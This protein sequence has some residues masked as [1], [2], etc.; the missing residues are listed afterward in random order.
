MFVITHALSVPLCWSL[1]FHLKL[2]FGFRHVNVKASCVWES[3]NVWEH[4]C[5]M[6][7]MA[8]RSCTAVVES[9]GP[10]TYM[11]IHIQYMLT[12][13]QTIYHCWRKETHLL[14][15]L[16]GVNLSTDSRRRLHHTFVVYI[17]C[18]CVSDEKI[19][20]RRGKG[21]LGD[22]G[23]MPVCECSYHTACE[24]IIPFCP[25]CHKWIIFSTLA[26]R[27]WLT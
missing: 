24:P 21:W 22:T 18:V 27:L 19:K 1:M 3:I 10:C 6:V 12:H 26:F 15:L 9:T 17:G 14:S 5:A 4:L 23:K 13:S 16:V 7:N 25:I 2:N 8:N 11:Y 20:K